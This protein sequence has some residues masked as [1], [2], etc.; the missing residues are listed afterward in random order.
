MLILLTNDDGIKAQGLAALKEELS[1]IADVWVAAPEGEQSAISH[2]LTLQKPLELKKISDRTFSISGTP[3]DAVTIAVYGI[4]Q[5]KPDLLISGI[6]HGLNLGEDVTYSGTVAG[7][8][9]G[10]LMGIPSI[11]VSVFDNGSSHF[12]QAAKFV[13]KL[14]LLVCKEGLPKGTFLNVN[15]PAKRGKLEKYEIT[16][17]GTKTKRK[18]ELK[19]VDF[20][21]RSFWW[22]GKENTSWD[23]ISGTDCSAVRK[24]KVSI[25]PLH[26]ELTAHK[27][28]ERIKLWKII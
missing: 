12:K 14:A 20:R 8:M 25:T 13:R 5:D 1:R 28:M 2:S 22:I 9:E 4:L 7:A 26:L 11:A 15:I 27:A 18:V 17:L 16:K 24:G 6:N 10:T 21:N 3:A 19:E 23:R